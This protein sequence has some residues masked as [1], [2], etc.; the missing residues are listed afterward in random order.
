M[1]RL[2]LPFQTLT[3]TNTAYQIAYAGNMPV[4]VTHTS[5]GNNRLEWYQNGLVCD[6]ISNQPVTQLLAMV[7]QFQPVVY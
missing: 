1:N 4:F 7:R 2:R 5:E 6:F 3:D